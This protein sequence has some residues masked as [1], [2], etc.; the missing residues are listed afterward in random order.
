MGKREIEGRG[1]RRRHGEAFKRELVDRSLQPGA[2]VSAL[3]Q[4]HGINANL[5]FN[6]RRLH[7]RGLTA[8]SAAPPA[9]ALLPVTVVPEVSPVATPP[10]PVAAPARTPSGTIEIEIGGARVRVRGNVDDTSLRSIL[11]ALR[12][13]A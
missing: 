12:E 2:S 11:R 1:T 9:P 8:S 4:E 6:W 10:A 13:L 7:L 5:L 3:A